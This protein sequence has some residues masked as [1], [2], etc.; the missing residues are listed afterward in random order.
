MGY[1]KEELASIPNGANMGLS[2]GNPQ[3]IANL[4]PGEIVV[5]LGSGGGFD[6]FLA[7]PKVGKKDG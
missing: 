4:K 2:C 5:D 7:A 3:T 1:T 6:C